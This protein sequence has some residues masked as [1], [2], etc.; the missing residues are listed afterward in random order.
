LLCRG[1]AGAVETA[2]VFR[3]DDKNF[4]RAHIRPSAK[5]HHPKS[6]V[7]VLYPLIHAVCSTPKIPGVFDT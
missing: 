5:I 6:T 1:V 3:W 7:L 4:G 2:R